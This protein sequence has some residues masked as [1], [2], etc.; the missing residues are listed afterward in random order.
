MVYIAADLKLKEDPQR[1]EEIF[2]NWNSIVQYDDLVLL[3]GNITVS[4]EANSIRQM[5]SKLNGRKRVM[6]AN[7]KFRSEVER[8]KHITNSNPYCV[9]G[10]VDGMISGKKTRVEI[11]VTEE[12][13]KSAKQRKVYCAAANSLLK[14][15]E[16]FEKNCLDI[17]IEKWGNVPLLY[18]DIPV[19]IN[20]LIEFG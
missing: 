19:L 8:L 5:F 13:L 1:D 14:Q 12:A 10:F 11:P 6:D 4:K 15:N 3:L 9:C 2:D 17:S 18:T 20:N 16:V 7:F